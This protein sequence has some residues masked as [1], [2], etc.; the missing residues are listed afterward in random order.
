MEPLLRHARREDLPRLV[1]IYNAS[2]PAGTA[3][4]DLTPITVAEREDWFAKFDPRRRPCWV[5]EEGEKILGM[6]YLSD[7]YQNRPAYHGTAE[8]STYLAPEAQG[9]GLGFYLKKKMIEACPELGVTH[10]I[11]IFFAHNHASRRL[12][13]KLG[14]QECGLLPRIA[15]MPNGRQ[16]VAL[17]VLEIA[18]P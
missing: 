1:E 12:N 6:V 15:A 9:R 18:P 16:D 13:Q 2:I 4:A 7:F 8:I 11:S 14:F 17:A 10:L 3:T 5:A